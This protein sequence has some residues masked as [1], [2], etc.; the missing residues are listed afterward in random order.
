M[1]YAVS[2]RSETYRRGIRS[3]DA[4]DIFQE[5]ITDDPG[6]NLSSFYGICRS[7]FRALEVYY[8]DSAYARLALD[9]SEVHVSWVNRP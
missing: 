7:V 6:G 4:V 9:T 1:S 8:E 5:R 2:K 3:E